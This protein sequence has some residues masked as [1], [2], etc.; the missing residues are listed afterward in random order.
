MNELPVTTWKQW[1]VGFL[2][3]TAVALVTSVVIILLLTVAFSGQSRQ[4]QEAID[5]I[6]RGTLANVCV[7]SLP[8][9][10]RGR[11]AGQVRDCLE[12]YGLE[13]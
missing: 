4:E 11:D 8:V 7:L 3:T 2:R 1:L 6:R 5:E 10:D 9:T 12:R 13:P